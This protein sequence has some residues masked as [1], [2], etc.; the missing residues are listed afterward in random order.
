M[1]WNIFEGL[2]DWNI[3]TL[4]TQTKNK[5]IDKED[6]AFR[7]I[8]RGVETRMSEKILS[9]MYGAIRTNDESAD[10]YYVLQWTTEPY[11]LQEDKEMQGY[12]PITTAYAGEIVCDAVFL[13]PVPNAKYW[14]TPM[15][16]GD[17]D[18]TV[19]L[20]QVLLPNI[21]M[22][23]ID[24]I[25]ILPKRCNKKEAKKLGAIRMSND[26]IDELIEEIHRRDKLDTDFDIQY[27]GEDINGD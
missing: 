7:T 5:N 24:K 11:T 13:N 19:R 15:I 10:G 18:V 21:T 25:N 14:Y 4:V 22:I 9:I 6:E 8:L 3:I 17:G 26:N 12:L 16:T 23:K 27:D 20:K 2:N 1:N